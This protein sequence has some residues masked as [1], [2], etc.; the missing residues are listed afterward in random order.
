MSPRVERRELPVLVHGA[1]GYTGKLVAR[2]LIRRA[3]PFG[4]SGRSARKLADLAAALNIPIPQIVIPEGDA[5]LLAETLHNVRVVI[6]CAGPYMQLGAPVVKAAIASGSHYLDV[7]GEQEFVRAMHEHDRAAV[8]AGACIVPSMAFEVCLSDCAARLAAQRVAQVDDLDV[9]YRVDRAKAS[10]GTLRTIFRMMQ[11]AETLTGWHEVQFPDDPRTYGGFEIPGAELATIPRHTQAKRVHVYMSTGGPM[12]GW[13][14]R[15]LLP[16][17]KMMIDS[18][19]YQW[20]K[21]RVEATPTGTGPADA[22]RKEHRWRLAVQASGPSG[23]ARVDLAGPDP[24]GLT[25]VIAVLGARLMLES[26]FAKKG[27]LAPSQAFDASSV[28][29]ALKDDG[30][31]LRLE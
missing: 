17:A 31:S 1:T 22:E 11:E 2:E 5:T 7:T 28:L 9:T 8:L 26:G 6:N 19:P 12:Q 3:I 16:H 13:L 23:K 30:V 24:Y 18:F 21:G 14:T 29:E 20:L 15:Q 27:V 4:I 25:A 10:G